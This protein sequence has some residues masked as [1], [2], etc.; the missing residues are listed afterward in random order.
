MRASRRGSAD[1]EFLADAERLS[2]IV[3][4]SAASFRGSISAEH[5]LGQS[6]R[7]TVAAY[8]SEL[9]LDLMRGVKHLL[10]PAGLMNPGKVLPDR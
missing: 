5:G 8:K 4:D 1:A 2:R 7:E 9:E 10:D 3:H 6:K